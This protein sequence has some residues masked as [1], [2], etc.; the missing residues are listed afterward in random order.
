VRSAVPRRLPERRFWRY[1]S[2]MIDEMLADINGTA[3]PP[4]DDFCKTSLTCAAG[5]AEDQLTVD[6]R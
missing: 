1:Q 4:S 2:Q 5:S 6:V 3:L